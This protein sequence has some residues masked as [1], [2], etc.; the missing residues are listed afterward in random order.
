MI[1]ISYLCKCCFEMNAPLVNSTAYQFVQ[2]LCSFFSK[3]IFEDATNKAKKEKI[4]ISSMQCEA[5]AFQCLLCL[6]MSIR[7]KSIL[8]AAK[9]VMMIRMQEIQNTKKHINKYEYEYENDNTF[10]RKKRAEHER[11]RQEHSYCGKSSQTVKKHK[12]VR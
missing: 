5:Y 6:M 10:E 11:Q 8:F 2:K 7:T 4:V 9:F 12:N 1:F 3:R